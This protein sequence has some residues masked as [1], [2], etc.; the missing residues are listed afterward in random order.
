MDFGFVARPRSGGLERAIATEEGAN[1]R[2]GN[3]AT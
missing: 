2:T 1:Y 3:Y